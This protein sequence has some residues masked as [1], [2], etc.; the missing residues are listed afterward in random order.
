MDNIEFIKESAPHLRRKDSLVAMLL[1]VVIALVPVVIFAF[2]AWPLG[3][4]KNV[5]ISGGTGTG[6][7]YFILHKFLE[8]CAKNGK[9]ILYLCNRRA[10][11]KQLEDSVC[12]LPEDIRSHITFGLYQRYSRF[13]RYCDRAKAIYGDLYNAFLRYLG[14]P[15]Q[16]AFIEL[17]VFK[18]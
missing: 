11:K 15:A 10:L 4:L 3:A 5:L 13:L 7:T 9:S 8:H 2:I 14:T 17:L 6:K 16:N 1:D 18:R 12:D